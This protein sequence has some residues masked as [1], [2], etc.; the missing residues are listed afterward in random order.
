MVYASSIFSKL[1]FPLCNLD[2][3]NYQNCC[4]L[5]K[6]FY[7]HSIYDILKVGKF[8]Q[9]TDFLLPIHYGILLKYLRQS[10]L[11]VSGSQQFNCFLLSFEQV[12]NELFSSLKQC[13]SLI[14]QIRQ[15]LWNV[16]IHHLSN[17]VSYSFISAF[18]VR[19]CQIVLIFWRFGR[20]S[21]EFR[22][23]HKFL[24]VRCRPSGVYCLRLSFLWW[25]SIDVDLIRL[26][27][28]LK[29]FEFDLV[30]WFV[31]IG[32]YHF[33]NWVN[34]SVLKLV[35]IVQVA[36]QVSSCLWPQDAAICWI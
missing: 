10:E 29:S 16:G 1:S 34:W 33:V 25:R 35:Y 26:V 7:L 2:K 12:V 28:W 14:F 4:L 18:F 20:D 13:Q 27:N 8:A 36:D 11:P 3:T 23:S 32:N 6:L 30:A 5:L 31:E 17:W 21:L 9:K 19:L 22:S 15:H 24:I